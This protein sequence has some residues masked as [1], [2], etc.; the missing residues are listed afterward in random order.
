MVEIAHDALRRKLDG[1]RV[2]RPPVADVTQLSELFARL[3][4]DR[5]RGILGLRPHV[6]VEAASPQ[7]QSAAQANIAPNSLYAITSVDGGFAGCAAFVPKFAFR[8]IEM[9]TGVSMPQAAQDAETNQ[10]DEVG[11][12]ARR[13]TSID[14][15]L[16]Q[17]PAAAVF[18][19]FIDAM[20][21][22]PP[23][24]VL[25]AFSKPFLTVDG[26]TTNTEPTGEG[27]GSDAGVDGLAITLSLAL[28]GPDDVFAL[29]V[30]IPLTT[31]DILEGPLPTKANSVADAPSI[32]SRTMLAAARG[33]AFRMVGVLHEKKMSIGDIRDMKVGSVIP[34]PPEH[35]M[36]IDLRIDAPNGVTREPT[37]GGGV[38]GVIDGHR[39]VRLTAPPDETFLA[40]LEILQT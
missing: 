36:Q 12:V 39:A 3:L 2:A 13:L 28:S 10:E 25:A 21:T 14:E 23:H 6:R 27:G 32:W 8:L 15:V 29:P 4:E 40:H 30:F 24:H 9:M 18:G 5:L 1:L 37:I 20:P 33:A 26:T 7:R 22:D 16:L 38:L 31:L 17:Y 34:L 11:D 35:H 19:A